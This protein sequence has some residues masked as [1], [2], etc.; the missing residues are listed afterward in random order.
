MS[1]KSV[2]D[3]VEKFKS[4]S[5]AEFFYRNKE[6]AGFSNP[7]RALYQSVRELL[8]NALDATDAHGILPDIEITITRD[9]SKSFVYRITVKDNGIGIP[10]HYVPDAFGRVLFSSKYV[11]RQTR[12]MFGLGA[13]MVV[14]YGQMTVGEPVEIITSPIGSR[15]VYA[16]KIMIDIKENKPIV[17]Y[18][19]S[20]PKNSDWHGTIV[21]VAIEGDWGRARQR[22]IEYVRRTAIVTPYANIVMLTPDNEVYVYRRVTESLPPPPRETKPHPHGIDL[23]MLKMLIKSS[24]AKTLEEFL[25][26]EFQG[27][28]KVTAERFMRQYGFDPNRDPR[29]F[30]QEELEKLAKALKE[31]SEFRAPRAD[32][33]SPIGAELIKLG[34]QAILKPE[35]VEAVTRKPVVYEGHALIVE[36]GLAYGG[37]IPPSDHPI[38]LRYANKIPLL[39]DEKSD[40]S[41]KVVAENIDWSYYGIQFPAPLAILVHVC[42]TKIPYKG[43]GKE[44]IADVPVIESEIENGLRQVARALKAYLAKKRREEELQRKAITL[45]KYIPEVARSL[46]VFTRASEPKISPEELEKKLFELVKRR[47]PEFPTNIKDVKD[48]VLSIE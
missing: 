3:T 7:A 9:K 20:W 34:L 48:V 5:P 6:I 21:R 33:L 41:W 8:E 39:Y 10:P 44:S 29:T 37:A 17:L 38:L 23:E 18:K 22:V 15:R 2:G 11:L 35:F 40:V 26:K 27:V 13:K 47:L 1:S 30:T 43:V 31:Y 28:G 25:I 36:V 12:G 14:L 46:A 16:F 24:D 45:I 42:G 32:H 4:I 19:A